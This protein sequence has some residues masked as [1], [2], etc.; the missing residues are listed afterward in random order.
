MSLFPL[1]RLLKKLVSHG[2]LTLVGPDGAR[3]SFGPGNGPC[4]TVR[5]RDRGF[6]WRAAFH[7]SMALGEGYMD[8]DFTIE[9]GTLHGLLEILMASQMQQKHGAFAE[10]ANRA[11][12]LYRMGESFNTLGRSKANVKAHYD[13]DHTLFQDFLDADMQYSCAYWP[14]GVGS[15]DEAQ[16][17]KKRHIARK[18]LLEPGMEV[19]DIGCG[20]GGM[21]LFLAR[22]FGVKVTGVT[23]SEDQ[24]NTAKGR[25]QKAGLADR[26]TIKLLDYRLEQ[27][28]Y[29]R[30]VSVGMFEHIGRAKF[31]EYFA[32]VDR[33]LKP[34]GVALIHSIAKMSG[35]GPTNDW[36]VKYIF[37]GGYLPTLS[38]LAPVLEERHLWLTDLET[39]RIHYARTLAEWNARFQLHRAETAARFDERFCRM[40]EF[41]LQ[42]CETSFL[43]QELCVFQ[44]QLAKQIGTVPITRDYMYPG[45]VGVKATQKA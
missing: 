36:L 14:E 31:P 29:D 42:A 26:V 24:Y 8:G 1:D 20:W 6:L 45:Q 16:L 35:P 19:L 15:L 7:P 40:W 11:A 21:A 2:R 5:V 4:A 18:L 25:A 38:E 12:R 41:Y 37:P 17:A 43:F 28:R 10:A 13:L 23:L 32:H 33:L 27:G 44:M 30:V 39:L 9:E 3:A 22:D 34:D